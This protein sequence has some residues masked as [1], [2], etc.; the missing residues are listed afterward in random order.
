M[1]LHLLLILHLLLVLVW[2]HILPSTDASALLRAKFVRKLKAATIRIISTS[3]AVYLVVSGRTLV[4]H[5]DVALAVDFW[6]NW[7]DIIH[8]C[9]GIRAVSIR[10]ELM[11]NG[12]D[13][14][15]LVLMNSAKSTI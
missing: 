1:L 9:I 2:H 6:S 3:V 8:G 11:R 14:I 15:I 12:L 10:V 4:G 13:S 7:R 5:R